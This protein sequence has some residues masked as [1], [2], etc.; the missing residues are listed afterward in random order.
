MP[1]AAW[2]WG[3][4]GSVPNDPL[5]APGSTPLYLCL[6]PVWGTAGGDRYYPVLVGPK[7]K[8]TK[9]KEKKSSKRRDSV[10]QRHLHKYAQQGPVLANHPREL[11]L[12]ANLGTL[13]I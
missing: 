5:G 6:P 11:G 7:I 1:R 3:G 4:K 9:I 12:P 2:H 8:T 13:S 10:V